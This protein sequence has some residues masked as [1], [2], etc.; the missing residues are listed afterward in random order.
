MKKLTIIALVLVLSFSLLAG[1]RSSREDESTGTTGTTQARMPNS[2]NILPDADMLPDRY[3]TVDPSNG[4]DNGMVDPT[5]GANHDTRPNSS[6]TTPP[7][8]TTTP[9]NRVRPMQ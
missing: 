2:G 9:R 5:N 6:D 3:D 8:S 1:C 4:A 7:G